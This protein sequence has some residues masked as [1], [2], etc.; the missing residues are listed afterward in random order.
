MGLVPE[1]IQILLAIIAFFAGAI[2]IA[3]RASENRDGSR[4]R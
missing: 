3:K 4:H 1:I 2:G